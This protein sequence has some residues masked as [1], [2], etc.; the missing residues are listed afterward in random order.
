MIFFF[1]FFCIYKTYLI[2]AEGY[3]NGWVQFLRVRETGE[4]LA[5]MKDSGNGMGVK[6][7]SYLILKEIHS[8]LKTKNPKKEQI[9][10]Y[11]MTEREIY[12]KFDNLSEEKLNT[13][14]NKN[15]YVRND[16]VTTI[17]KWI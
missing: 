5:S 6:N 10:Q 3:K 2:S 13:K 14:S 16:V 8:V 4:I 9:N 1:F 12:G 7:I 15:I 11:K 17:I